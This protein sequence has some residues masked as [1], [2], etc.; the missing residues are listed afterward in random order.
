MARVQVGSVELEY[1]TFG[2]SSNP[3]LLLVMGL[4]AQ[5]IS[6]DEGFCE[7]LVERGFFVV[8]F[9]NRDVGL[10]TKTVGDPPDLMSVIMTRLAGGQ[11]EVAYL[12]ADMATDAFGVLDALGIERAHIVGASMGGMIVQSM[13]IAH[14]E[15]VLS[16]TSIMST[17][18]D[19]AVGQ[20]DPAFL[21]EIMANQTLD[22]AQ[23]V[24]AG[25]AGGRLIAGPLYD[26]VAGRAS[27]ERAVARCFNPA[28]TA[29]QGAAIFASPDRTPALREL[30]VPTLVVHGRVDRL[31][32]LSGGEATAAAI[33]GA[34]LLVLDEMAH[35][36]PK[37]LWPQVFDAISAVA[38]VPAA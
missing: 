29:F 11:P 26:E 5:M 32:P 27:V 10:S 16:L 22:P 25:I 2:D 33:P 6:W 14:P 36:L 24:E 9:D 15:R 17:T 34:R 13:A 7:G 12:L 35:D 21:G 23:A 28:G 1:E 20:A 31:V 38:G 30:D 37:P 4:G 18:G 19:L 8:R 3:P